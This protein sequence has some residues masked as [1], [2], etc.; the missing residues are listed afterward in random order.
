MKTRTGFVSNSSSS[1]F[2]VVFPKIPESVQEV[3]KIMFPGSQK[4]GE[5][6]VLIFGNSLSSDRIA[7]CVFEDI[8][9]GHPLSVAEIIDHLTSGYDDVPNLGC[10]P[11]FDEYVNKYARSV[12]WDK[13]EKDWLE[14]ICEVDGKHREILDSPIVYH[15]NYGDDGGSFGST[16]EHGEIFHNLLHVRIS[17]H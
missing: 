13:Y 17:H 14:A 11:D 10:I 6:L 16:M 3:E 2:I 8:Q 15:F 7:K 5:D 1:S 4:S 12:D 9:E